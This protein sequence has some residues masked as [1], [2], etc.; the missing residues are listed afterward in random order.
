MFELRRQRPVARHRRPAIIEQFH[1]RAA[2]VDHR[3]DSE[4][5]AGAQHD[6]AAGLAEVNDIGRFVEIEPEAMAAKI[7]HHAHALLFG[8][9]LDGV[10]DI[11]ERGAGAGGLD[12]EHQAFIGDIDEFLRL[13]RHVA[14]EEHAAGIAVPAIDNDRDIDVD[15]IAV[16]E[17]A[18]RRNAVA[19]DVIDADAQAV[20]EAAIED[21]RRI[22]AGSAHE[23]PSHAI[24]IKRHHI[25]HDMRRQHVEHFGGEFAGLAHPGIA[26]GI[27][28]ADRAFRRIGD[29]FEAER[30][31][32]HR[33]VTDR[34]WG[35]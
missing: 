11:A 32:I 35:A 28:Q 10:A 15:D 6:A 23:F 21:G 5:H 22:M 24:K 13:Q 25:G 9:A 1:R 31:L 7:A 30:G 33:T 34:R 3:F 14:D 16:L 29:G 17:L 18:G 27:V 12:A 8:V 19:D 2:Q 20:A 4:E 26:R